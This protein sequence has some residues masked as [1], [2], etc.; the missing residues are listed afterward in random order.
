MRYLS[1]YSVFWLACCVPYC[2]CLQG[3]GGGLYSSFT[4]TGGGNQ[5]FP[6]N[7]HFYDKTFNQIENRI[8]MFK[9]ICFDKTHLK[10]YQHPEERNAP[11]FAQMYTTNL[12]LLG[13]FDD[14][15][16]H[17]TQNAPVD[18]VMEISHSAI[19]EDMNFLDNR[20]WLLTKASYAHK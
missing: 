15:E 5:N 17:R 6:S 18:R 14:A 10:Y 1:I 12:L 20:T 7:W 8:C 16:F 4:C 9:N 11:D 3:K 19:P 2:L 13:M